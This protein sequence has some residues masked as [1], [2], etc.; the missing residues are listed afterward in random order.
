MNT[1]QE[2][3]EMDMRKLIMYLS[4][5]Q[6]G[7]RSTCSRLEATVDM[8]R[9]E[10]QHG[11]DECLPDGNAANDKRTVARCG[12]QFGGTATTATS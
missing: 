1:G 6:L 9:P 12:S 7:C 10:A 8:K 2:E 3:F 4:S 11:K 5:R